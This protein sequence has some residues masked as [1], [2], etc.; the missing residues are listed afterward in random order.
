M[1]HR[2][3]C[4]RTTVVL[5]PDHDNHVGQ[6]EITAEPAENFRISFE[7]HYDDP[8]IGT[9]QYTCDVTPKVFRNEIAAAPTQ[10]IKKPR[11]EC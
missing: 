3:S 10:R 4:N 5:L 8:I 11:V 7:V 1:F 6:V 2:C 9:Q